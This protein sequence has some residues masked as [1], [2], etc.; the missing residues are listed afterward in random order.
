MS[1]KS[2]P[3]LPSPLGLEVEAAVERDPRYV[4]HRNNVQYLC[5]FRTVGG[6]VFGMER[7]TQ[8]AIN[9]WLPPTPEITAAIAREGIFVS[10]IKIPWPDPGDPEKYGRISSLKSVPE[11]RDEPLLP[12]PVSSAQQ[13]LAVLAALK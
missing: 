11:L 1:R 13:A 6:T 5:T 8:G 10:H 3:K 2:E 12:V 7:V 4:R 9:L